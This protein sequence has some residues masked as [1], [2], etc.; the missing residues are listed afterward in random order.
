ME[1]RHGSF[2]FSHPGLPTA[3]G[4]SSPLYSLHGTSAEH[5]KSPRFEPTSPTTAGESRHDRPSWARQSRQTRRTGFPP[6]EDSH[7]RLTESPSPKRGADAV[8]SAESPYVSL[9]EDVKDSFLLLCSRSPDR[10]QS[11]DLEAEI[12]A[13]YFFFFFFFFFATTA[14]EPNAV[15]REALRSAMGIQKRTRKFARVKRAISLRDSR[16]FVPLPSSPFTL[17][18]GKWLTGCKKKKK[19]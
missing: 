10:H 13:F 7:V 8:S 2:T 9:A 14:P 19:K 12:F 16:L 3:G 11:R 18:D 6:A 5:R 4:T 15:Q 1:G 17:F